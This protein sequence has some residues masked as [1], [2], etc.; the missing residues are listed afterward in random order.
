[1]GK[2]KAGFFVMRAAALGRH[3]LTRQP[4]FGISDFVPVGDPC[5]L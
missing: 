1:M 5:A 4:L 2:R 3:G